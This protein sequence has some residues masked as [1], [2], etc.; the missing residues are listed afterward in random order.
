MALDQKSE[1]CPG[2]HEMTAVAVRRRAR[3]LEL[4]VL[5]ENVATIAERVS[6]STRHVRRVL[7]EP[8]TKAQLRELE[9]E[10]LRTVARKAAAL[11]GSAV[12]VLEAIATDA[13]QPAPARVSAARTILDIMVKVADLA[14]LAERVAALEAA[15]ER[16]RTPWVRTGTRTG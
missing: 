1:A 12:D 11:G 15:D 13:D 16:E 14:D 7:A 6:L 9:D 3:I 5:G 10:R 4:A 2:R 8:E